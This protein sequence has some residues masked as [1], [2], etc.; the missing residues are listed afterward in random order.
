[1]CT[2]FSCAGAQPTLLWAPLAFSWMFFF[3]LYGPPY[4]G[5]RIHVPKCRPQSLKGTLSRPTVQSNRGSTV[6]AVDATNVAL[7]VFHAGSVKDLGSPV[8]PSTTE[9]LSR[10]C[11]GWWKPHAANGL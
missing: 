1:M 8:T 11:D 4:P 3:G 5:A 10:F 6:S 2:E 7:R 9:K